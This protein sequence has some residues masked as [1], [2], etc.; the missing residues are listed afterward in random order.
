MDGERGGRVEFNDL[1]DGDD[2]ELLPADGAGS[3][4]ALGLRCEVEVSFSRR[5]DDEV[6]LLQPGK[7]CVDDVISSPLSLVECRPRM[8]FRHIEFETDGCRPVVVPD[9]GGALLTEAV[10]RIGSG[11]PALLGHPEVD[12]RVE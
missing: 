9:V 5:P 8:Y 2:V 10:R 11:R 3:T 7:L 12:V 4:P 6:G 1:G